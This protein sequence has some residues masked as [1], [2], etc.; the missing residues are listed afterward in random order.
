MN[1]IIIIIIIF[2]SNCEL[3]VYLLIHVYTILCSTVYSYF[4]TEWL[5]CASIKH[6]GARSALSNFRQAASSLVIFHKRGLTRT[7][8]VMRVGDI[9]FCLFNFK[10]LYNITHNTKDSDGVLLTN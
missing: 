4:G 8:C 5:I 3:I 7:A 1:E 9:C 6:T 2:T 10:K